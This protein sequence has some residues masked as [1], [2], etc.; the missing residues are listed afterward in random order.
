MTYYK[1]KFRSDVQYD[2]GTWIRAE[3]WKIA[4][5]IYADC[6]RDWDKQKAEGISVVNKERLD[7]LFAQPGGRILEETYT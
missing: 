5:K 6:K 3:A 2:E 7:S 1:N 4:D